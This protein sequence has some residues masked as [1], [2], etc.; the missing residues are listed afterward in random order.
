MGCAGRVVRAVGQSCD[1]GGS[2]L[3]ATGTQNL[4]R[5]RRMTEKGSAVQEQIILFDCMGQVASLL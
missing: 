3:S 4:S 5:T 1:A 2:R